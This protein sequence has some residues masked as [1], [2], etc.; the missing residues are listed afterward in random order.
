MPSIIKRLNYTESA[1]VHR[2]GHIMAG[3]AESVSLAQ[4]VH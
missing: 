1:S 3:L 4:S 2:S